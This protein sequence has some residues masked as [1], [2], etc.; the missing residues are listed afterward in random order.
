MTPSPEYLRASAACL[1][2]VAEDE[3]YPEDQIAAACDLYLNWAEE[4]EE[5]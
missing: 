2:H 5:Q 4:L 3:F 1:R